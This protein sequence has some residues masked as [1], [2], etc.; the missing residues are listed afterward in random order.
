MCYK[1]KIIVTSFVMI[2]NA[3]IC[4]CY[5]DS[6]SYRIKDVM[7]KALKN[8]QAAE[9][10]IKRLKVAEPDM[11]KLQ[12]AENI[13]DKAKDMRDDYANSAQLV[14]VSKNY[15]KLKESQSYK[16]GLKL[17]RDALKK[18]DEYGKFSSVSGAGTGDI[19]TER[20]VDI[21]E[22]TN[23]Y[24]KKFNEGKKNNKEKLN[25]FYALI[26]STLPEISLKNLARDMR[27][28][29]GTILLRGMVDN[30]MLKTM[31]LIGSL[32][33]EGVR[34][35]IYPKVFE[36]LKLKVVPCYVLIINNH[37]E[38]DK[39]DLVHDK[40]IGNVTVEYALSRFAA[41]GDGK[42]KAKE[43]LKKLQATHYGGKR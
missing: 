43:L 25:G 11:G 5:A 28:V 16:A 42:E 21:F 30:S 35:A 12:S 8:T 23:R 31:A 6:T 41:E 38:E 7:E 22:I 15:E 13:K 26:S 33:K 4:T 36:M 29:G 34:A 14:E 39:C 2:L 24:L 3:V 17:G 40:I 37:C 9:N 19:I 10:K 18:H 1:N 20:G 32:N 27:R